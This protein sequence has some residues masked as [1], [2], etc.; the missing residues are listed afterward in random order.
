[1]LVRVLRSFGP[2]PVS[3]AATIAP[4]TSAS[5][6]SGQASSPGRLRTR[7]MGGW[8]AGAPVWPS[9]VVV[10]DDRSQAPGDLSGAVPAVDVGSLVLEGADD[11]FGSAGVARALAPKD[12]CPVARPHALLRPG[13]ARPS[14]RDLPV[15]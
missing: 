8:F 3:G 15:G 7:L 10:A 14:G 9:A 5:R 13:R 11:A 2:A 4:S 6:A 12:G 1:M